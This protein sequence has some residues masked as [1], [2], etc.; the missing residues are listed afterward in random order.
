MR[1]VIHI[2]E[3]NEVMNCSKSKKNNLYVGVCG[4]QFVGSDRYAVV[5]TEIISPKCVRVAHMRDADYPH[6][7]KQDSNGNDYLE[8]SI[9]KNY[10]SL[11]TDRTSIKPIGRLFRLRKNGRWIQE[12]NDLWSTGAVHFGEADEY[13]DPSF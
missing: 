11:D 9:V 13:R 1:N 3:I 10:V 8:P 5:I 7:I 6:N 12:G 2:N 4:T